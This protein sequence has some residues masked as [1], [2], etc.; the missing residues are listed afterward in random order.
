[1][2][3]ITIL[4]PRTEGKRFDVDYYLNVHM[5]MS[6]EKQGAAM[7]G[8]TVEIG[9]SGV[10]QGT[11]PPFVAMCH[12]LYDSLDAFLAAFTPHAELLMGDMINYTDIESIVQ[13]SEVRIQQS[14]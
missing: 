8:V 14:N 2:V 4:Y 6:I 10:P 7:K 3:R 13:I 9:A 12:F 1:M 11:P 5:P